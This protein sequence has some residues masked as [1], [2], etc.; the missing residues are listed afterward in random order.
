MRWLRLLLGVL[1]AAAIALMLAVVVLFGPLRERTADFL[2]GQVELV[3]AAALDTPVSIGELRF[4]FLPP[5]LEADAVALGS[6]GA[7]ARAAHVTVQLLPRVSLSQMRP[8]AHATVDDVYVD[9]P[10]WVELIERSR[11]PLAPPVV[12]PPFRV[13]VVRVTGARVRLAEADPPLELS[14]ATVSGEL[15]SD[16][17]GRLHFSA[18]LDT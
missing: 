12:I 8:V 3:L 17:L 5:R 15:Q 1:L 13:R 11:V 4:T 6:D 16:A 10:R 7:L 9:V 14:A 2:R 18:D